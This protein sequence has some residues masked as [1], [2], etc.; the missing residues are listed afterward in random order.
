MSGPNPFST[1]NAPQHNLVSKVL[2]SPLPG[3]PYQVVVD[4]VDIHTAYALQLGSSTNPVQLEYVNQIGTSGS[5]GTG[6][7]S[8]LT[9]GIINCSDIRGGGTGGGGSGLTGP[10]GPTGATG[11]T[12]ATGPSGGPKGDP[13]PTGPIGPT[14]PAGGGTGGG[15]L[16]NGPTGQIAYFVSN[17][18]SYAS[19]LEY[20]GVTLHV[21]SV[22]LV[23]KAQTGMIGLATSGG[24]SSVF[25]GLTNSSN[26]GNYLNIGPFQGPSTMTVDTLQ[27][28]VGIDKTPTVALDVSGQT[29]ITYSGTTSYV[30]VSGGSGISGSCPLSAG[31]TYIVR[32]WGAGGGG[33][34]GVGG[35]GGYAEVTF[36]AGV[37][38][39]TLEWSQ[40]YGGA[41]GGGNALVVDL[42]GGSTF[43]YVPGGGAGV[44]GG[45]G[46]AAGE[47]S[48]R[49]VPE[50]GINSGG[51]GIATASC[52]FA[53]PW[54]YNIASNT[55]IGS[56]YTFT[57]GGN[58]YGT[59]ATIPSG[60]ATIRINP[61]A[62]TQS[63]TSAGTTYFVNP[64]TTI[65]IQGSFLF[66]GVTFESNPGTLIIPQNTAIPVTSGGI[67]G[68]TGTGSVLFDNWPNGIPEF[69]NVSTVFGTGLP[70]G[71]GQVDL[72]SNPGG[73]TFLSNQI[74]LTWFFESNNLTE[75]VANAVINIGAGTTM[76]FPGYLTGITNSTIL[77][78][79]GITLANGLE[80]AV[81]QR[82]FISYG[83]TGTTSQA[84]LYGGGG[85]I[86]GGEPALVKNVP[87]IL[88]PVGP[89]SNRLAGGGAGS[90]Y[91]DPLFTGT[92][93]AGSGALPY[94]NNYNRYG[95]YGS[96]TTGSTGNSG[97]LI[98]EQVLTTAEPLPALTVNG[99]VVVNDSD[100]LQYNPP[101]TPAPL[102]SG[103]NTVP[104]V[105]SIIMYA[106]ATAP[107]G[108]LFCN[109]QV[110]STTTY[111][112]LFSVI[113]YIY[114]LFPP[115]NSF[116]LPNFQGRVPVGVGLA[117]GAPG[118]L[119]KVLAGRGGEET[120]VLDITEMPSH[121]HSI[122]S[123][124]YGTSGAS[125]TNGSNIYS[126]DGNFTDF[127]GGDPAL[128][129]ATRPHNNMPPFLGINYIIK[130]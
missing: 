93:Y 92:T 15:Y 78:S 76:T 67:A 66:S 44:S 34:G 108:W 59:V 129:G 87:G 115:G 62:A 14:G 110:L 72:L 126:Y 18:L 33:N 3:A 19:G 130:F 41:S 83:V 120:H 7:F 16:P 46:A 75:T 106:G 27:G 61:P 82:E 5:S 12:G 26:N 117:S 128:G 65:N 88:D 124:G 77:T 4:L 84:G 40:L 121:R 80:L 125:I 114:T 38:G 68:T 21:P 116:S 37:S 98:V 13:G 90:W 105:G 89:P 28:Y 60:T 11:A 107:A 73:I 102:I 1:S 103:F 39:A 104:P 35:A 42:V 30:S 32:G 49:P 57:S 9:V 97:Y 96:G 118:A 122:L 113:G 127:T 54:K 29:I 85:Y 31:V 58:I 20:D 10:T 6:Y 119:L 94:L 36:N 71:V 25:S 2:T 24:N 53:G 95:V 17:G 74:G 50:G 123:Y 52:T 23:S 70:V 112:R 86:A 63:V 55:S 43:L 64:G 111:A 56:G 45:A 22:E 81:A 109:G 91:I 100:Y 48:G 51:T 101:A 79:G 69:S 99:D 8:E 47:N